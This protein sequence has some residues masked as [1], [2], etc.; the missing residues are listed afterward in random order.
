[1]ETKV[2]KNSSVMFCTSSILLRV[3]VE[4]GN[5]TGAK[6]EDWKSRVSEL[7]HIVVVITLLSDCCV[8]LLMISNLTNFF[9]VSSFCLLVSLYILTLVFCL[10][11]GPFVR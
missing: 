5:G 3:L 1:M 2:G 7:T 4:I 9:V 6:D 11:D 8:L 10:P